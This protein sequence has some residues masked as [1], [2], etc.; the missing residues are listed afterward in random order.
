MILWEPVDKFMAAN[1]LDITII[2]LKLVF[3][4]SGNPF[5]PSV[6][7]SCRG[8]YSK[9]TCMENLAKVFCRMRSLKQPG[10]KSAVLELRDH[11][12]DYQ[13]TASH[14]HVGNYKIEFGY[15]L[16]IFK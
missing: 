4:I 16:L 1:H 7:P 2:R 8:H 11:G 6:T 12:T 13:T 10:L 14:S 9:Q 3:K 5:S 15:N